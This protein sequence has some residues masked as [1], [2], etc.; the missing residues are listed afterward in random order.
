ML[1]MGY[2]ATLLNEATAT[3][4]AAAMSLRLLSAPPRSEK[5]FRRGEAANP[6]SNFNH[7]K[8]SAPNFPPL[9]LSHPMR[10]WFSCNSGAAESFTS[11]GLQLSSR[12]YCHAS[13]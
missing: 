8:L 7:M 11:V 4:R 3:F 5:Y 6:V 9:H 1:Q 13:P 2:C 10:L 12:K